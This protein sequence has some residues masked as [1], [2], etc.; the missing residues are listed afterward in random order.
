MTVLLSDNILSALGFTTDGN[1]RR[2]KQGES[3]LAR[4]EGA[5]FGLSDPL[6]ASMV[7]EAALET[8]FARLSRPVAKRYTKL[9][10]AV[11]VSVADAVERAGIDPASDRVAFILSTTKGNVH[12]LDATLRGDY[13]PEQ[14]YLWRSAEWIAEYFGNRNAPL[15]VSNACISGACALMV[16]QRALRARRCDYAI[17]SGADLLSRFIVAGFQSFRALSPEPCKPFDAKRNGLNVGETAAT[18][19]LTEKPEEAGQPGDI[20]LSAGAVCNDA[21]HIS[22][23]SRT[24]EGAYLALRRTLSGIDTD[25]IAFVNAHGT[26]TPYNDEMEA[27]AITRAALHHLPVTALKG[28]FGH[29]LG[30]AGIL[31]SILVSR[32]LRE[33]IILKTAGFDTPGVSRPLRVSTALQPSARRRCIT[34]LSGFAGCNAALLYSRKD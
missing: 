19:I 4:F 33:G 3:G 21:N 25:E 11:I 14:V 13:E 22:G 31:E 12:L 30:S 23:P 16:A 10:K 7:D 24:G 32:A 8:A 2:V 1:L 9:E 26:A 6:V 20:V 15:V 5:C 29:T 18:L 28:Y 17:V 27:I 34:M